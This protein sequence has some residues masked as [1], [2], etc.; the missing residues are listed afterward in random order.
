MRAL[1]IGVLAFGLAV[2]PAI[3]RTPGTGDEKDSTSKKADTSKDATAT[4]PA[5]PAKV[6]APAKPAPASIDSEIQQLRE[7]LEAQTKQLQLQNQALKEQKQEMEV[8]RENLKAVNAPLENEGAAAR[9]SA[10]VDPMGNAVG[11]F[12]AS[13]DN[14]DAAEIHYKG[15]TLR[16]GGFLAAEAVWRQG[17]ETA[18]VNSDFKSIPMP[19]AS[20]AHLSDFE[21]TGRQSQLNLMAE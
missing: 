18:T 7:M 8:M 5:A 21:V 14:P 12:G 4:T 1:A 10:P 9:S 15:I 13:P 2:A 6:E 17:A 19:G 16:P 11:Y 3:A 20:Q